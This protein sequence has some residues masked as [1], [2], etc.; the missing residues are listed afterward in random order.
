MRA[1]IITISTVLRLAAAHAI[2]P[3]DP[4]HHTNDEHSDDE[5]HGL[6]HWPHKPHKIDFFNLAVDDRCDPYASESYPPGCLF[7]GY[8]IKLLGGSVLAVPNDDL[9]DHKGGKLRF[10]KTP[11][12]WVN[13]KTELYTVSQDTNASQIPN[14]D[15]LLRLAR[16]RIDSM[17]TRLLVP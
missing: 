7:E 8:S 11:V 13:S 16:S 2:E 4:P 10:P 9:N 14:S 15:F 1:V 5:H 17:S 12:F 6:Q 3:R